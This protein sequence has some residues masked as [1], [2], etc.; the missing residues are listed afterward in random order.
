MMK[1]FIYGL[2]VCTHFNVGYTNTSHWLYD[3]DAGDNLPEHHQ[4][5]Y[6]ENRKQKYCHKRS[7]TDDVICNEVSGLS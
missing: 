6:R 5:Y 7:N 2:F 1:S 4:K 3:E